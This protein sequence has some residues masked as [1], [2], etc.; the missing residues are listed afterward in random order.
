[1]EEILIQN[2]IQ[3]DEKAF[4]SLINIYRKRLFI[5]ILRMCGNKEIAEDIFQETLIRVWKNLPKYKEN[6][7]FSSWLFSIAHNLTIDYHRKSK[8]IFEDINSR[9]DLTDSDA[10]IDKLEIEEQKILLQNALDNLTKQQKEVFLLRQ[11]GELKFS[12]IAEL[13]KQPL[14]TVL[15]HMNYGMKK[16]KKILREESAA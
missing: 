9:N 6:Q 4:G 12:E 14:N 5:Y 7:K 15:S 11:A 8:N 16:L 3:R 2:S 10:F 1:M 13:T